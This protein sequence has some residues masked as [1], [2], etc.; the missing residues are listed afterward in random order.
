M[1]FTS[2][3]LDLQGAAV[4]GSNY[5][6]YMGS[7]SVSDTTSPSVSAIVPTA[8]ATGV[9][10]NG[11]IRVT[12]SEAVNPISRHAR[13]PSGSRLAARRSGTTMTMAADNLSGDRLAAA[14]TARR[15]R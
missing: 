6:F 3:L 5:Y 11:S 12:F 15:R 1:Y 13:T 7:G 10:V 14:A 2:G 4:A 8:G 9:G